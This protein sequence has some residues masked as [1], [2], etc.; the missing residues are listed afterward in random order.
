ML[1][2][3]IE[4]PTLS[5]LSVSPDER[6][7]VLRQERSLAEPNAVQANWV[8]CDLE[9]RRCDTVAE[10][11]EVEFDFSG[12]M[13]P[14]SVVWRPDSQ[15]FFFRRRDRAGP[16]NLWRFD[17]RARL[18]SAWVST[19]GDV[20]KLAA[21]GDRLVVVE[22]PELAD[23]TAAD[24]RLRKEGVR[25]QSGHTARADLMA[26]GLID[27]RWR[28]VVQTEIAP[29]KF[30]WVAPAETERRYALSMI[31]GGRTTT[32][33][34]IPDSA[35]PG[36]SSDWGTAILE[37][38]SDDAPPRLVV[39]RDGVAKT[40]LA[41]AC[42][43][44]RL[45]IDGWRQGQVVF[46]NTDQTDATRLYAW[47]PGAAHPRLLRQAV[48]QLFGGG[49]LLDAGHC[50]VLKRGVLCIAEDALISAQL[51]LIDGV[52]GRQVLHRPQEAVDVS[53]GVSLRRIVWKSVGGRTS[54]G[55]VLTPSGAKGPFPLV[56]TSYRCRNFADGAF[57][58]VPELIGPLN[59]VAVLCAAAG[60]APRGG[61]PV[62]AHRAFLEDM[63]AGA[64]H[65]VAQGVARADKV[66]VSG[67]S[68]SSE[69]VLIGLTQGGRFAA[70]VAGGPTYL[71]APFAPGYDLL[72]NPYAR[73]ATELRN[74][75]PHDKDIG[76]WKA[77]APSQHAASL[78]A[79]L[80]MNAPESE[81]RTALPL[82]YGA[83]NAGRAFELHAYPNEAHLFIEPAHRLSSAVRAWDWLRFWLD[84]TVDETPVKAPQ[85]ARWRG[86]RA[87]LETLG[88]ARSVGSAL[89]K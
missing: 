49:R 4:A 85:Y 83:A 67:V 74:L 11:G 28:P 62:E 57:H 13:R 58:R 65:L 41:E 56:I 82:F 55:F 43:G 66:A 50:A 63:Q 30:S 59:G 46:R 61:R 35:D 34:Q 7:A 17:M 80:L 5:S 33:S 52:D 38:E 2:R 6:Y 84:G 86:L 16:F 1:R 54:G 29:R 79:P 23:V 81:F 19:K 64:A 26:G 70:A 69:A 44:A 27:G 36:V 72:G 8:L 25:I 48:G 89:S 12:A 53:Q 73:W 31:D 9:R 78:S 51:E 3:A 42:Q 76:P 68:F 71:D 15:A 21:D 18:A 45:V 39:R 88:D 87:R 10:A 77:L 22:G 40:C 32:S 75:P 60:P 20:R 24:D 47:T 37:A 14:Q